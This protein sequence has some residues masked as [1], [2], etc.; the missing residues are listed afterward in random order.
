[1]TPTSISTMQSTDFTMPAG[2]LSVTAHDDNATEVGSIA[3]ADRLHLTITYKWLE[4]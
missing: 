4:T 3:A 1:M 2:W